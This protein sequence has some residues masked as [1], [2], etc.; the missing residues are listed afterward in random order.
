MLKNNLYFLF[1]KLNI[2]KSERLA[3]VTIT[4]MI[5]L[6]STG[7]AILR[8]D[9]PFPDEHY[10][11]ADSLFRALTDK[12]AADHATLMARYE[13]P[14]LNNTETAPALQVNTQNASTSQ[15]RT[16]PKSG[17]AKLPAPESIAINKANASELTRLPGIG[18]KTAEVIVEYR[19]V[20]GPFQDLSH[21]M[22][23]KGIGPKKW[24]QIRPYLRLNE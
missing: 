12:K 14:P 7:A 23:V 19:N 16:P 11:Y 15:P 9:N 18:P 13:P 10:A 6:I 8:P 2:T 21:V 4:T 1:D 24:E 3:M 22:R 20:H 17:S 5:V